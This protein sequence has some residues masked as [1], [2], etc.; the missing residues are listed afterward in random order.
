[1]TI[2]VDFDGTICKYTGWPGHK[3]DFKGL[4]PGAKEA[5]DLF[6]QA[7]HTV[8][9]YTC[10]LEINEVWNY[11][12]DNNISFHFLNY[13]PQNILQDLHPAKIVADVY[14]DD[15]GIRFNGLWNTEFINS[16][17]NFKVWWKR[18]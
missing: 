5:L 13:N 1:M 17:L 3:H 2:A 10:R 9:V 12:A 14:I 11:L 8:I 18:R 6:K 4:I 16:V 7:G 15:R